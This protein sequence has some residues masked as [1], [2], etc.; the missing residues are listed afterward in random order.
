MMTISQTEH[1]GFMAGNPS[2]GYLVGSADLRD[3][4][5]A[6]LAAVGIKAVAGGEVTGGGRETAKDRPR[7]VFI[8]GES[9]PPGVVLTA[10]RRCHH[11]RDR[12]EAVTRRGP[13][14]DGS[15][16]LCA[17]CRDAATAHWA[18]ARAKA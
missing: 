13:M 9:V 15:A 3:R 4:L 16:R 5:I 8:R 7:L 2:R 12:N 14:L 11:H 10:L 6:E 17:E 18:V 1:R